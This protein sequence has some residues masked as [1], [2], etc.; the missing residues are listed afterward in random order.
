MNL[1]LP[2]A[3]HEDINPKTR[4]LVSV[5]LNSEQA[6]EWLNLNKNNRRIR[7]TLV[8]YL[9][10]QIATGEWQ[11][12]HPQPIVFSVAGRLIDGQHRLLAIAESALA[13]GHTVRVRVE[14][15]AVDEMREYLDTGVPRTLD[16]RV[17]LHP[18]KSIN[19]LASQIIG[20]NLVVKRDG[21]SQKF[22]KAT[23]DDAKEFWELHKHAIMKVAEL[24]QRE[25]GV[26]QVAIALAAMEY[27]EI[28]EAKAT[29]FYSDLFVPAGQVNQS[30]MLR[31]HILRRS[32][33]GA[34]GGGMYRTELYEKAVGCMKAH[35]NNRRVK[36]VRSAT[37]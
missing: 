21:R 10:R 17:E 6:A 4:N 2:V 5:S 27:F 25:R 13:N 20:V 23:P 1:F 12:D 11:D 33:R 14:T 18:T 8:E 35:L 26:G 16:D 19:K 29:E 3:R 37:W 22:G 7:R 9:K 15:G 36:V 34:I 30:Q 28:D 32:Q 31:D 24:H